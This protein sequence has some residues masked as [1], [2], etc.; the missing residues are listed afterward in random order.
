MST[1]KT[2][3]K[4]SLNSGR[5][6]GLKLIVICALV[7]FM[8]IPAMF[9]SYVSDER[10]SRAYDVTLEV[11]SRYGGPQTLIGPIMSV[12]YKFTDPVTRQNERGHYI[13]YP[14]TG[15]ALFRNVE[16]EVKKRSLY[17]VPVYT[18]T[19]ELT[20]AFE[21]PLER[22][23]ET[24][25][26]VDISAARILLSINDVR[27]LKQD[28]ILR[29][30]NG[31]RAQFEPASIEVHG[32]HAVPA[33][34]KID[35]SGNHFVVRPAI[36]ADRVH[37]IPQIGTW[38]SV[39]VG[40]WIKDETLDVAAE[41][42]LSGAQTLAV[43]P[44]AK[45]TFVEMT[46]AWPAPGFQ[47]EFTPVSREIGEAGFAAAW[48]MPYLSRGIVGQGKSQDVLRGIT[49]NQVRVQFVPNSNPYQTVNRALK[50]SVLFI[51]M[52]FL[53]YFLFEVIVGVPV[54]PAQY[55]LIGLAQSIFY[56]LLL[57]F[58]E[59]IGFTGAFLISAGATIVATAGYAG[60]VFGGKDYIFKAGAVFALA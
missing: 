27:G 14:D 20:A 59:R 43:T 4:P 2:E 38:L 19:G 60:A 31:Q 11:S 42:T 28:I 44:F 41:L 21:K 7:L 16:V 48:N 32:N 53:A 3:F 52:V 17:R 22:L 39:E 15:A 58:S 1:P 46:S 8:P 25:L 56:L 49:S 45:S 40:D 18:A 30:P 29:G 34:T 26:D 57:A 24:G 55:I 51:G 54:H 9:I 35:A 50:Y 10:S 13:L 23:K 12:P 47:G 37:N 33:V 6:S 5:S 36:P